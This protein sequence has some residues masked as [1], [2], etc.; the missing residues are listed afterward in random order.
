MNHVLFEQA[1]R[2]GGAPRGAFSCWPSTVSRGRGP[3]GGIGIGL[4]L[5]E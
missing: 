5:L 2:G 1:W 4:E 3:P